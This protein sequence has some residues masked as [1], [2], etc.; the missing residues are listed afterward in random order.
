MAKIAYRCPKCDYSFPESAG[1][2]YH[3]PVC[4]I[5]Y[6]KTLLEINKKKQKSELITTAI[7]KTC[8][9]C[10]SQLLQIISVRLPSASVTRL[11]GPFFSDQISELSHSFTFDDVFERALPYISRRN[12]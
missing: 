9:R 7:R 10:P 2:W 4:R 8:P 3:C 11:D 6:G 5:N 12:R 1:Y